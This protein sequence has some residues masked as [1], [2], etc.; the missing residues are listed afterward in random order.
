MVG[1]KARGRLGGQAVC[2][3]IPVVKGL[4]LSTSGRAADEVPGLHC[5]SLHSI[6]PSLSAHISVCWCACK[7]MSVSVSVHVKDMAYA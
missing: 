4:L 2:G 3:C 6:S 1:C 7:N 5:L